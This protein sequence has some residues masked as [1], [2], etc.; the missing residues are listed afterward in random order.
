M[1]LISPYSRAMR[2]GERNPKNYPYWVDVVKYFSDQQFVQIG[3]QGEK[4]LVKDFRIN[5]KL[6]QIER[7]LNDCTVWVSVDNFLPHWAN[8]VNAKQGIVIWGQSDPEIFG[9]KQNINLLKGREYLRKDQFGTWEACK[10]RK[11]VFVEPEVV[12]EAIRMFL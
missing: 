6:N 3:V 12:A 8:L 5:L 1:I 2:N 7:L 9:Y 10:Y 4:Q 11:D